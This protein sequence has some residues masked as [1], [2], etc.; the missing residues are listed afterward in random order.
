MFDEIKK[1]E[2][3]LTFYGNKAYLKTENE[4]VIFFFCVKYQKRVFY[5]I[6]T[7]LLVFQEI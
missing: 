1:I 6:F 3:A 4:F 2:E 5:S 7:E